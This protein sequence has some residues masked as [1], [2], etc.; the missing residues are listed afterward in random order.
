MGVMNFRTGF[1]RLFAVLSVGWVAAI[2]LIEGPKLLQPNDWQT[3]DYDALAGQAGA[4]SSLPPPASPG[5]T[6]VPAGLKSLG[7]V[8]DP[9]PWRAQSRTH[10]AL[11]LA[12][13]SLVPPALAYLLLFLTLPW[14]YRG[15]RA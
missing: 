4:I 9:V 12:A 13:V 14:I 6:D 8:P 2:L 11:W 7:F 10:F 3:V 15:F 1:Q 5:Y